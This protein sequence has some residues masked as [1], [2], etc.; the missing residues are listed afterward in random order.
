[1]ASS[2]HYVLIGAARTHNQSTTNYTLAAYKLHIVRLQ[3]ATLLQTRNNNKQKG[4][5]I[6]TLCIRAYLSFTSLCALS[7]SLPEAPGIFFVFRVPV[8]TCVSVHST[9]VIRVDV[10][11]Q[12]IQ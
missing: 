4:I 8:C 10:R 1:M 6:D 2:I 12:N 3:R 11:D 5:E 9:D 7:R